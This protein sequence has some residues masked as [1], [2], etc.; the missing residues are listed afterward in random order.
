[1]K[2][3]MNSKPSA[4]LLLLGV[5]TAAA[6]L[7]GRV[8]WGGRQDTAAQPPLPTGKRLV[9]QG[10]QTNVGSFPINMALSPDGKFIAVTNTGF[11]Q[12]LSILSA[13]DGHLISQLP[14]NPNAN[15]RNDKTSL[16]VGLVFEPKPL[17]NNSTCRLYA[18]RGPEDKISCFTLDAEGRLA[19]KNDMA[20]PSSLPQAAKSAQPNFCAHLALSSD[21][22][23][24]YV[25]NNKSSAYTDFKG[26]I[27]VIPTSLLAVNFTLET[28]GHAKTPGF[29]YAIAVV[30]KGPSAD[31][32]VYVSSEQD[33]CVSV[34]LADNSLH[35]D[36]YKD[37]KDIKTG[38]H[39]MALLLDKDAATAV[40]RQRQQRHRQP[41]DTATD[42]VT[43]TWNAARHRRTARRHAHRLALSPDETRL[44]V[45]LADLNA[46][47]VST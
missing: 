38:D 14:F 17:S 11:R 37:V 1:M 27:S 39:P 8:A 34:L 44:Y 23:F 30:T 41:I 18:S 46:L 33:G 25:V 32:K 29:P 5:L 42:T 20:N 26:S 12:Y 40:R 21:G 45:T 9:L 16:Y 35:N 7:G 6:L 28:V 3:N 13:D 4:L 19:F 15:D 43:R 10:Q 2:S 22:G 24:L 47:A 36:D 31:K